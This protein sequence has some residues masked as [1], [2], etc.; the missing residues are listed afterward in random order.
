VLA[1]SEVV[2]ER[3]VGVLNSPGI[4]GVY[5]VMFLEVEMTGT[6]GRRVEHARGI[7]KTA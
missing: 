7:T 3:W 5:M 4:F 1:F 6:F 2:N